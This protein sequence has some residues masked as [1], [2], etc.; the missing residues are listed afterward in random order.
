MQTHLLRGAR[1]R[2]LGLMATALLVALS[3]GFSVSAQDSQPTD[4]VVRPAHIHAGTCVELDPNPK[5]PLTSVMPVMFGDDNDEPATAEDIMGAIGQ[6]NVEYSESDAEISWDE[7]LETS[8][9]VNIHES[10]ANV[11]N[12]IA[13]G[14]IGGIVKDDKLFIALYPQNDSGF[15]GVAVLEKDGDDAVKVQL[16]LAPPAVEGVPEDEATPTG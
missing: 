6:P 10:E 12:Y 16:Y 3:I 13:C 11:Q 5:A 15:N 1:P 8:H 4:I 2:V 14:N 9:A 7:M